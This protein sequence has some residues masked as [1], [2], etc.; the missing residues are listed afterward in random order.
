MDN[1]KKPS[2]SE[3]NF[4]QSVHEVCQPLDA[5]ANLIELL[6]NILIINSAQKVVTPVILTSPAS[7]CNKNQLPFSRTY[8]VQ[9]NR[10]ISPEGVN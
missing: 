6:N 9:T 7:Y 4:V 3:Y 2:D 10:T 5:S 1:V 8:K